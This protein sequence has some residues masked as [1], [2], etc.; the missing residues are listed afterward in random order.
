[1]NFFWSLA[2]FL[3]II[4]MLPLVQVYMPSCA[5]LYIKDV[6]IANG[7]HYYIYTN[8]LGNTFWDLDMTKYATKFWYGFLRNDIFSITHF[9][10]EHVLTL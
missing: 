4:S 6:S 10:I 9:T 1:M 2:Y 8:F 3:Q 5:S 7:E